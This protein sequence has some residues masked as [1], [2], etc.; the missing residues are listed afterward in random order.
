[1]KTTYV[2][3]KRARGCTHQAMLRHGFLAEILFDDK[4]RNDS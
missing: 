1:M 3:N 4:W 2:K